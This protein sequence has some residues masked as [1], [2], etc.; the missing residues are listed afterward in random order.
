VAGVPSDVP[1]TKMDL[2][3]ANPMRA[4]Q[5]LAGLGLASEEWGGKTGVVEC[6][7]QTGKGVEAI[8][9]R[10]ALEAEILE[11][12]ASPE[13]PAHGFVLDA[14]VE[15][16]RGIVASTLVRDGTLRRGDVILS[17]HS[18]GRVRG[19]FDQ[20]GRA[21]ADAGP[22]M[23][24]E[25]TG[26]SDLP[27]AGDKFYVLDDLERARAVAEK[28][29]QEAREASRAAP[30][31]VTLETLTQHLGAGEAAELRVI[32]KADVKGTL[33]AIVPQLADLG[34]DEAHVDI[35]HQG[36]GSVNASDVLLA[37][38]SDGICLGFS[39]E[40]DAAARQLAELRGVQI[41]LHSVIYELID[42]VT[43]GLEGELAPERREVV[44]GHAE[45]RQVF[46]ISRLGTIAGSYVLD[47]TIER[48]NRARVTREGAQVFEGTIAGLKRFQDDA[49]EVRE[50]FECGIRLEGFDA[51]VGDRIEAYRIDEVARTLS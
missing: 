24:V 18:Y 41:K 46:R 28:R 15:E 3:N 1:L 8:L 32:L 50:G 47:G 42:E 44:T 22:S 51:R 4:K 19:I 21:I 12:R 20:Y 25:V 10:I 45:V 5:Q 31:H 11:L 35:I 17:S 38:A 7:A 40:V 34:G 14:R 33:E 16:G 9:E 6:S 2:P 29:T 48:G 30:K 37:D 27:E 43:Q 49:R 39:V 13:V 36:V 26:L 23:P